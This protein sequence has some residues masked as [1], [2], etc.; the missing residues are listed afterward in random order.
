MQDLSKN[1]SKSQTIE[2]F[3]LSVTLLLI[4]GIMSLIVAFVNNL[5]EPTIKSINV[6]KTEKALVAVLPEADGFES[7]DFKTD[8]DIVEGVWRAKNDVGFCVKVCPKGYG[9]KIET[10]VGFD[11]DGKVVGSEIVSMSE[12]SGIGTKIQDDSFKKQFDG[13]DSTDNV[14]TVSGA[15]RSSKAYINGIDAAIETVND[16]IRGESDGK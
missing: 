8:S 9:G 2:F 7:V 3:R 13:I 16:L 5:T 12:T 10:I 11:I 6:E 4:A 14:V 15:T 1:S